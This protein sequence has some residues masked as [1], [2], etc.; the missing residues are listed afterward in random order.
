MCHVTRSNCGTQLNC[1]TAQ[2]CAALA[3]SSSC[4]RFKHALQGSDSSQKVA[5]AGVDAEDSAEHTSQEHSSELDQLSH[6][7]AA[8]K[9]AMKQ[10]DVLTSSDDDMHNVRTQLKQQTQ[11]LQSMQESI[12]T[13]EEEK[14]R[15]HEQALSRS[16]SD[17]THGRLPSRQIACWQCLCLSISNIVLLECIKPL[18]CT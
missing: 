6:T 10:L 7:Q 1:K 12:A 16:I 14:A 5:K 17:H 11:A 18:L 15:E 9:Q 8:L 2:H 4:K 13:A 3:V